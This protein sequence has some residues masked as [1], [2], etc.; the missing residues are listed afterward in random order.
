MGT[1]AK[2][3][4]KQGPRSAGPTGRRYTAEFR[5]EALRMIDA[6]KSLT[7][8]STELGVSPGTL[9][10]WRLKAQAGAISGAEAGNAAESV[11]A[12]NDRL[13]RENKALRMDLEIAKKAAA[14]FARHGV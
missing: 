12:E 2:T 11:T 7:A 14:F 3:E 5:R 13:R 9:Q 4:R 10:Q 6:G 8:V 1:N